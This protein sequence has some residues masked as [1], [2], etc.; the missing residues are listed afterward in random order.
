M[1]AAESALWMDP[2][3]KLPDCEQRVAPSQLRSQK[4]GKLARRGQRAASSNYSV[5]PAEL[6]QARIFK[7]VLQAEFARLT[8]LASRMGGPLD[9][10]K[11]SG[12]GH[13]HRELIHVDA[14]IDEV[15]KLLE[16]LQN[17]FGLAD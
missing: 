10:F 13:E 12:G 14:C 5:K 7:A 9:R 6:A 4:T 3:G 11:P 17:R 2:H 8:D 16:G 15:C 1:Q